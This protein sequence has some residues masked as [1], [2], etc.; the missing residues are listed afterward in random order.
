MAIPPTTPPMMAAIGALLGLS[1]FTGVGEGLEVDVAEAERPVVGFDAPD[2][3]PVGEEADVVVATT[4]AG[5][6]W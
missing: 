5:A 3:R 4:P 2:D 1:G 6:F